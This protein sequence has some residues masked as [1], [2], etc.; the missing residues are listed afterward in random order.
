M[1]RLIWA[2]DE[3]PGRQP[4]TDK[5]P[6]EAQNYQDPPALVRH[7]LRAGE[8]APRFR[9]PDQHGRAVTLRALLTNGPVVLRFC[10][11]GGTSSYFYELD[12]L[13]ALHVDIEE[14]GATLAV[15]AAQPRHPH[16][17]DK[18]PVVYAFPLLTD[19]GAKVARSYGLTYSLP[20]V[21]C[22]PAT[23]A[24][25]N[26]SSKQWGGNGSAPAI[27]VIDQESVVALAF[28]DLEGRSRM[29]PDQIV[30]ALECLSKRK[31]PKS[32]TPDGVE[33]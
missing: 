11:H 3:P 27:Y 32:G 25:R 26:E 33:G 31:R 2:N 1:T 6:S 9:L 21:G 5:S 10:R 14:R 24:N 19:K 7:A 23:A 30:M 8:Q 13:A 16:P 17:A 28:V 20:P 22:S 4:T 29:E 15:I 18:D 12:A